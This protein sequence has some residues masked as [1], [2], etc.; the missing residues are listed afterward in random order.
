MSFENATFRLVW[1]DGSTFGMGFL[2]MPT[3][4]VTCAHLVKS[5][6]TGSSVQLKFNGQDALFAAV[7]E[8]TFDMGDQ[9]WD[10]DITLLRLENPPEG[11]RP[12]RLDAAAASDN[13]PGSLLQTFGYPHGGAGE[14]IQVNGNFIQIQKVRDGQDWLQLQID[15]AIPDPD[16]IGAPVWDEMRSVVA[17]M[18]I[19]V[20]ETGIFAVPAEAIW[21][22]F[23]NKSAGPNDHH[24]SARPPITD[25]PY[26]SVDEMPADDVP[27]DH[28]EAVE[29]AGDEPDVIT[30]P[31]SP[32]AKRLL[33]VNFAAVDDYHALQLDEP[34]RPGQPYHLLVDVGLA[35]DKISSLLAQE[36]AAF[37]EDSE[38]SY[39]RA[40]DRQKGWFDVEAVFVSQ[41]FEPNLVSG[42]IRVPI[43]TLERSSPYVNGSINEAPGPLQLR[44]SPKKTGLQRA[45][46]RLCLYYGAQV[47]QSAVIDVGLAAQG[48]TNTL[49]NSAAVDYV[50]TP[51]FADIGPGI[52]QRQRSDKDGKMT[53]KPVKVGLMLNDDLS[54]THRILLK[55]A[56]ETDETA[57]LPPAWKAYDAGNISEKLEEARR[58][59]VGKAL[60]YESDNFAFDKFK[61]DLLALAALGAELYAMLLQ[62]LT[63]ADGVSPGAWRQKFRKALQPG[64]VIQLARAASVP[65][66]H[67][68]PWALTYDYPLELNRSDKP[69]ILCRVVAEQWKSSDAKRKAPFKTQ[70]SI[71]CPYAH[72]HAENTVC[73]FGFWGYK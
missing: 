38:V 41:E 59:L 68:I 12:L 64:E 51:G 6:K 35:W 24:T 29:T 10:G 2:I 27:M 7:I 14:G 52:A 57:S 23:P 69:L 67:I 60:N 11:I 50:L 65:A 39:L 54:G 1:P 28:H 25:T 37:P 66:T 46:G 70:E 33:N 61:D 63:P 15:T 40:E 26:K 58:I 47:L 71:I 19:N 43:G 5:A 20:S 9:F 18:V 3:L 62:G 16:M 36:T 17:G 4:A 22:L 42:Y 31:P 8:E 30:S 32:A 55:V 45:H 56:E 13:Q 72:E 73:P 34:L 48:Q 21:Q 44:V 49:P 53:S